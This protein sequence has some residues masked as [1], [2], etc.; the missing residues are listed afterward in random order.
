MFSKENPSI[1]QGLQVSGL[2]L[3]PQK[4]TNIAIQQ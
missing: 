3:T 2:S 1:I 4:N